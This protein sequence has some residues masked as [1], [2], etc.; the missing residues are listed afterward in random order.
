MIF[1]LLIHS[2]FAEPQ[3]CPKGSDLEELRKQTVG[4]LKVG[5]DVCT[6]TLLSPHVV[7]TAGH[8][9]QTEEPIRFTLEKEVFDAPKKPQAFALASETRTYPG[10]RTPNNKGV[11]GGGDVGLV[12]LITDDYGKKPQS[13][14]SLGKEDE[15]DSSVL[16]YLIGYGIDGGGISKSQRPRKV[17]FIE[18]KTAVLSDK[19]QIPK[20]YFKVGVGEEGK[21]PCAGDSGGPF[22]KYFDGKTRI[23]ALFSFLEFPAATTEQGRFIARSAAQLC[24]VSTSGFATRLAPYIE[25][26]E[27]TAKELETEKDYPNCP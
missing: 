1:L 23:F 25:W 11:L 20:G 27:K 22:L 21:M 6:G 13:Y 4:M 2:L 8:C 9:L 3:K 5:D 24:K 26:I 19:K 18:N 15:F 14:L 10:F 7:L 17:K 16:L 12:Q